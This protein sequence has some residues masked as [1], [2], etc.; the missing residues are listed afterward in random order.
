MSVL[1]GCEEQSEYLK[2]RRY[3][4]RD[5][6]LVWSVA[7]IVVCFSWQNADQ[8]ST[9]LSR[10]GFW[11]VITYVAHDFQLGWHRW[12][13]QTCLLTSN[14]NVYIGEENMQIDSS[15]LNCNTFWP[16][17][18]TAI[19]FIRHCAAISSNVLPKYGMYMFLYLRQFLFFHFL[20]SWYNE[21]T[22]EEMGWYSLEYLIPIMTINILSIR[23]YG[24]PDQVMICPRPTKSW[25]RTPAGYWRHI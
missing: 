8:A 9:F 16:D 21:T 1:Y 19:E 6:R 12:N 25:T 15:T 22:G 20:R 14:Y 5:S 18:I 17:I 4:L 23:S 2:Q 3:F 11:N 13:F 24:V 7:H 10:I